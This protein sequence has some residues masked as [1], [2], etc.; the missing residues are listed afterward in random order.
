MAYEKHSATFFEGKDEAPRTGLQYAAC[1]TSLKTFD[2]NLRYHIWSMTTAA[3][4]NTST[5][6]LSKRIYDRK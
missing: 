6:K 4:L 5:F 3:S 1:S 2:I